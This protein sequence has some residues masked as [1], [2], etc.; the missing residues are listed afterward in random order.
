MSHNLQKVFCVSPALSM[1][2]VICNLDIATYR[3]S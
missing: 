2:Q 3:Y 1:D